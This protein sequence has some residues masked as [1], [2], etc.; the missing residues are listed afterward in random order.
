LKLPAEVGDVSSNPKSGRRQRIQ[1]GLSRRAPHWLRD[2]PATPAT[3]HEELL[4]SGVNGHPVSWLAAALGLPSAETASAAPGA[5]EVVSRL[6]D[7]LL[8]QTL[9]VAL[10]ELQSS[11][12]AG[13]LTLRDPQMA[14]RLSASTPPCSLNRSAGA[15]ASSA[16]QGPHTGNVAYAS[17]LGTEDC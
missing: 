5:E 16:T 9:R 7:A 2:D 10:A 1:P 14:T 3:E 13:V 6:A 11:D 4:A 8:A 12:G 15:M 17:T